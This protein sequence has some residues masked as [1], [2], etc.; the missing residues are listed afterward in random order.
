MIIRPFVRYCVDFV[1]AKA[2]LTKQRLN[3]RV[4]VRLRSF[5]VLFEYLFVLAP[6]AM[7]CGYRP[8]VG[9]GL[10]SAAS[11]QIYT[12]FLATVKRL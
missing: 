4:V 10:T 12:S 11:K 1:V 2:I 5:S 7:G 6:L 3:Q 9:P 8:R